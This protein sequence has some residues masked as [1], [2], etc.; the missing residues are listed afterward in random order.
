M[1]FRT[2]CIGDADS[3]PDLLTLLGLK[4]VNE[5][6]ISD[7]NAPAYKMGAFTIDSDIDLEEL[8]SR[9][10]KAINNDERF[11]D[12]HRCYQTLNEGLEP[13][14]KWYTR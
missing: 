5:E 7:V 1:T 2:E 8:R 3:V 14:E 4:L 10:E 12:M 11:I 13:D 6:I 9:M